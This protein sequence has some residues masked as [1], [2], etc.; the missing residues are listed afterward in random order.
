MKER[1]RR[2]LRPLRAS[3]AKE[4]TVGSLPPITKNSISGSKIAPSP[5]QSAVLASQRASTSSC[6]SPAPSTHSTSS[7]P[8]RDLWERARQ[9]LSEKDQETIKGIIT[10]HVASALV[11]VDLMPEVLIEATKAKQQK[12]EDKRWCFEFNGRTMKLRDRAE[13]IIFWLDKF[14]AVGDIAVNADSVHAGL[15]WAGIRLLLQV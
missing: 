3:E 14:K 15:P 1:F 6:R 11:G 7:L 13:R 5:A 9:K 12:C 8:S 10:K 2:L 4:S